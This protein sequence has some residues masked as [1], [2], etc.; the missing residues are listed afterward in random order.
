MSWALDMK[1]SLSDLS[2]L[3]AR[4]YAH[5]D[6]LDCNSRHAALILAPPPPRDLTEGLMQ[7]LARD[8]R[9]TH[10]VCEDHEVD[11]NSLTSCCSCECVREHTKICLNR[12]VIS[13]ESLSLL[14]LLLLLLHAPSP[15]INSS[16]SAA[17]NASGA[18]GL[19]FAPPTPPTASRLLFFARASRSC[20]WQQNHNAIDAIETNSHA[21]SNVQIAALH[22]AAETQYVTQ[23]TLFKRSAPRAASLFTACC[24]RKYVI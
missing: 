7:R 12:G 20:N 13:P 4:V 5:L 19:F 24:S 11:L 23:L 22:H 2:D 18:S 9:D 6:A 17:P 14:L 10:D 16:S 21:L 15:I 8:A 3:R 1:E